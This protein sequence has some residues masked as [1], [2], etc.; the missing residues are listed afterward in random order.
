MKTRVLLV[1]AGFLVIAQGSPAQIWPP[2]PS[3]YQDLYTQLDQ[4]ITSF[5]GA[6]NAGWNKSP[7]PVAFSGQ[8]ALANAEQGSALIG[9]GYY[10]TV[11][12][13]LNE[14]QALGAKAVTVHID[15]PVLCPSFYQTSAQFQ[16][17]L[18]FYIQLAADIRARGMKLIIET[19]VIFTQGYPSSLNPLAFYNSLTVAQYEQGRM[20]QAVL[21][22]QLLKPD[23][24]TVLGE[25]DT[26]ATQSGK[27]QFGTVS[28]A[29][30]LLKVILG[31]LQAAAVPGVSIGAGVGTWITNY[32]AYIQSFAATPINY[33]DMHI[34]PCNQDFMTRALTIADLAHAYGK[35]VAMTEAW[36]G[37]V[38]DSELGH[39]SFTLAYVRGEYS[40]WEPI[41]IKFLQAIINFS[42]YKKLQFISPF[43]TQ[44]L[45]SYIAYDTAANL[46]VVQVVVAAASD[47]WN[48]IQAGQ[49]SPTGAAYG[50]LITNP[51]DATP[52][53]SP[54]GLLAKAISPS[55]MQVVWNPST[56]DVGI[57]GYKIYR[58]GTFLLTT[59][60][61]SYWDV[62][63][64]ANTKYTYTVAS[65]DGAGNMSSIAGPASA[66]TLKSLFKA[67]SAPSGALAQAVSA[68]QV[69]VTWSA[70]T[71]PLGI[72]GYEV[73]RGTSPFNLRYAG[74]AMQ[75]SYT[76]FLAAANTTYYYGVVAYD[77][78]GNASA[79]S[80]IVSVATATATRVIK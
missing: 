8:L 63:L 26:E 29:T 62:G 42:Q 38:R 37:K 61:T 72:L 68:A 33:I 24:L 44:Y 32:Q 60:A 39:M 69:N 28:G 49:F 47:T 71:G 27:S 57:A 11:L 50:S 70:S 56:D 20:Q 35:S 54:G 51:H 15:F 2:V 1:M 9:S 45:H 77:A 34:Y 43:L 79:M 12:M 10:N 4:Q 53:A 59:A 65:Y 21:I 16:Q 41:D 31:G 22:A 73:F 76:D 78:F 7:Y 58:N 48:A 80:N 14:L 23:Y 36:P 46:N 52:P 75:P 74:V 40:F 5:S 30:E 19:E 55:V 66:T 6:V 67:P 13:E 18:N 17:Y 25:P 64:N 3:T